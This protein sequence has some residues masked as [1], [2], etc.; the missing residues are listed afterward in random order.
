MTNILITKENLPK[1][2]QGEFQVDAI[3]VTQLQSKE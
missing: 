1:D 3:I 2:K